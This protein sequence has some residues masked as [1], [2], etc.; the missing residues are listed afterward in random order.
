MQIGRRFGATRLSPFVAR[1][2]RVAA[3]ASG[4]TAIERGLLIA[5]VGSAILV[6]TSGVQSG[7]DKIGE[8]PFDAFSI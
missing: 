1:A 8:L 2:E 7:F 4:V 3:D 5:I 6:L